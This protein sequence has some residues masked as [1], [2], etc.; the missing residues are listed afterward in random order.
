[1]TTEDAFLADILEHPA[2]DAPRLI[3]ADWLEEN[4][5]PERAEFIR[6]MLARARGPEEPVAGRARKLLVRNWDRWVAPLARLVGDE[7]YEPWLMAGEPAM[8]AT[9][10]N[11][12]PRGFVS[13]LTMAASRFI[14]AGEAILRLTPL[15]QLRLQGAGG[16]GAELAACPHLQW[17]RE[18]DFIDYFRA[19][20]EAQDMAELAASPH[21]RRLSVLSLYRNNLGDAGLQA[22]ARATWLPGLVELDLTENGLSQAGLAALAACP[23]LGNLRVLRL[24]RD[25]IVDDD[26][27]VQ[28][29]RAR[30]P[31]LLID[32]GIDFG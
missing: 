22:L 29:L 5:D 13:T 9:L 17:I 30:A 16:L 19:P 32:F 27:S 1:V 18:I 20:V 2:D 6:L 23:R 24:G 8:T 31:H 26:P 25:A 15:T 28:A 11:H 21:L 10:L 4:G 7:P 3:F 12:F 14:S